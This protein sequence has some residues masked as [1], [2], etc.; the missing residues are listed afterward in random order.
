MGLIIVEPP[1]QAEEPE[2]PKR[3]L[4]YPISIRVSPALLALTDAAPPPPPPR[5]DDHDHGG[6]SRHRRRDPSPLDSDASSAN[7]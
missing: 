2:Q 5:K 4:S 3:A 1:V 6:P 7:I